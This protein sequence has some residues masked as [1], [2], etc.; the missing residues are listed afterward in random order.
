VSSTSESLAGWIASVVWAPFAV[1]AVHGAAAALF[2]HRTEL[3]PAFHFF[4]GMAGAQ[5][6][7]R[8]SRRFDSA[9]AVV[10]VL[11]VALLWELM[12]FGSDQWLGTHIQ[13]GWLDTGSDIV[14]GVV[15]A[16]ASVWLGRGAGPD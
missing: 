14:L 12:E 13:R 2:G 11:A 16:V 9:L 7:R 5:A 3:D 15:G 6:L 4:G 10:T 1:L 8:L